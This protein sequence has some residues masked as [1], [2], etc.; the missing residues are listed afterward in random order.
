MAA[1]PHLE[2][3]AHSLGLRRRLAIDR[4]MT[5]LLALAFLA[6][7]AVLLWVLGYVA[8]K[9]IGVVGWTFWTHTPP[10]NPGSTGGGFYNGIIGSFIIV[11]I[12]VGIAVPLGIGAA[13]YL[14]EY[15]RGPLAAL[16]R[17]FADVMTGIPTIV[18]GAFVYAILVTRYGFSG[19]AGSVSL[20]LVMYP[21]VTRASEEILRLI[22]HEQ[23]QASL[24]L[25]ITNARTITG[26]ILPAALPG[27]ITG[28]MLAVA[29]AMGETAP[30]LL[31]ALG[32]DLFTET[33][34]GKRMTTLS[35]QIFGNA[36]TGFQQSQAR[37]WAGALT[38]VGIVLALT[39]LARLV[40]RRL[41]TSTIT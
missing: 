14:A 9:G 35:L 27:L 17:F 4:V 19:Y 20:A 13:V 18:L 2:L 10:G 33:N 6:V 16:I 3:D 21:L 31:T 40:S 22:P 15:G 41:A 25:G 29:R 5:V 38:L 32:N 1:G 37:A 28:V 24:A 34:P 11:G 26:I 7:L 39:L 8:A 23:R 30:L 36:I 12:A